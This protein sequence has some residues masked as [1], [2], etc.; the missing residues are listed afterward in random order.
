MIKGGMWNMNIDL[1]L[2]YYKRDGHRRALSF[3]KYAQAASYED[4]FY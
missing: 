3:N 4:A 2:F 1:P